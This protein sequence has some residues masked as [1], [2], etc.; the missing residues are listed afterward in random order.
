[1]ERNRVKA[2]IPT[3]GRAPALPHGHGAP[4]EER[5]PP[6]AVTAGTDAHPLPSGRHPVVLR[7]APRG[8]SLTQERRG[9]AERCPRCPQGRGAAGPQQRSR[10]GRHGRRPR[11]RRAPPPLPPGQPRP[12]RGGPRSGLSLPGKL[13]SFVNKKSR[14]SERAFPSARV[15]P[16]AAVPCRQDGKRCALGRASPAGGGR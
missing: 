9:G 5:A 7:G 16:E 12:G 6:T 10:H 4:G 13:P 1:M 8:P 11:T 14:N 2:P 3:R 15:F